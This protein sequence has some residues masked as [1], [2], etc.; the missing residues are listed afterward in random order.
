[1]SEVATCESS[2]SAPIGLT[3]LETFL[4][5]GDGCRLQKRSR[6]EN[7]CKMKQNSINIIMEIFNKANGTIC[8]GQIRELVM[9]KPAIC[10]HLLADVL[11]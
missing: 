5:N 6:H 4:L 11:P 7:R 9:G 3:N 8:T 1:M 10:R 2:L